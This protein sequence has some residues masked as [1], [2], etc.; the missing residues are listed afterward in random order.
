M[1][2]CPECRAKMITYCTKY[3]KGKKVMTLVIEKEIIIKK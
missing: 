2:K 1:I 3:K